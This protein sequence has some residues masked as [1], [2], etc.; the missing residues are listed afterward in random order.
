MQRKQLLKGIPDYTSK[1]LKC[2]NLCYPHSFASSVV[3]CAFST[4]LLCGCKEMISE[5]LLYHLLAQLMGFWMIL[6]YL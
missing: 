3:C 2:L 1:H 6:V 4:D 5:S